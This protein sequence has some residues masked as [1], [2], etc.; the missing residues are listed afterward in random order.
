M[1]SLLVSLHEDS[2]R[3]SD[4]QA[5]SCEYPRRIVLAGWSQ[6]IWPSRS[7]VYIAPIRLANPAM[8]ERAHRG[9]FVSTASRSSVL[10]IVLTNDARHQQTKTAAAA[11][12]TYMQ[13]FE[14]IFLET[15]RS[16]SHTVIQRLASAARSSNGT[17]IGF[18]EFGETCFR[19]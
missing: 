11:R 3:K 9:A 2:M 16:H 5:Y 1:N 10:S 7:S 4:W 15:S 19:S 8:E 18:G 13:G 14:S 6:M 12:R 17:P